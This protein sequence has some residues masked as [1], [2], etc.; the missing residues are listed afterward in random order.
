MEMSG[1][2]ESKKARWSPN[3]STGTRDLFANYGY[4]NQAAVNQ[5]AAAS[6]ASGF[7]GASHAH[8]QL[9]ST[10]TLT[11]NT[12]AASGMASQ[13]SPS[14]ATAGGFPHQQQQQQQVGY[15]MNGMLGMS[16]SMPS[17]GMLSVG[18]FPYSPQIGSFPQT[19]TPQQ[20]ISSLNVPVNQA[21]Y[22]PVALN[23]ALTG[24]SNATARTVYV[25]RACRCTNREAFRF[26]G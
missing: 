9:Y 12:A 4:G 8:A 21:A 19:F 26:G 18:G 2:P 7:G 23:A 11:V 22:S 25:L 16:M 24:A 14:S 17:M 13:M 6:V 10:P 20:R 3:L 15:G 5:A 1:G